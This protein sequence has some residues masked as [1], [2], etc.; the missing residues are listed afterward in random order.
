[1]NIVAFLQNNSKFFSHKTAIIENGK[2]VSYKDLWIIVEKL[3]S[4]LYKNGIREKHKV[5]LILPSSLEFICCFLALLKMDA[6]VTPLSSDLTT[7]EFQAIFHNLIP[8]AIISVTTLVDN[9]L[10][11][12]PM[13]EDKM[14]IVQGGASEETKGTVV[15]KKRYTLENL[16][17]QHS[18][19]KFD[20]I[21]EELDG[22]AT[23]NYTYRGTGFPLG[24]MLSHKNYI[25]GIIAHL[26]RKKT[27][28]KD[29]VLSLLPLYHTYPLVDCVL[30][31]L[32]TGA[33]IV[34]SENYMPRSILKLIDNFKINHF[35][36][37]P[38]V[39]GLLLQQFKAGEYNLKSL[40]CCITGGSYMTPEMQEGIKS[41]MGLDILQGYGLTECLPVTWNYYECN[42]VGTLGLPFR[43][44][45]QIKIVND[46]GV[47]KGCKE[48]KMDVPG[49][50]AIY[51]PTVMAGYY[52]QR[53]ETDRVLKDG[54]LY[55]GDYGYVDK[56]GYLHFT[57]L[58]KNIAKVGGRLV[59]LSEVQNVLLCH[60]SILD[61][62][63]YA[64]KHDLWGHIIAADVVSRDPGKLTDWEI[65]KFCGSRLSQFKVPKI[66]EV[67]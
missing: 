41:A 61:V 36:A 15:V 59:D 2:E 63:A 53:I 45:F 27:S 39:Y 17:S 8:H 37:V 40:T 35:T 4:D 33:T 24:V 20:D 30:G 25:E 66:I 34:V 32:A 51:S 54:W 9:I 29:K 22:I 6:I 28:H 23:I 14:L 44:D 49:E 11:E 43:H 13:L 19:Y 60:P 56:Q 50:I 16:Y 42:K 26:S 18:N 55:T 64:K 52:R 3:S 58:K 1:M 21:E 38:T 65:K 48:D 10:R 12:F 5:A 47:H 46:D 57:G 31:P 67:H 62:R 7:Y